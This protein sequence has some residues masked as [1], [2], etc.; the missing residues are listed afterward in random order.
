M[1]LDV[2]GGC[3]GYIDSLPSCLRQVG[4]YIE[5]APALTVIGD[6]QRELFRISTFPKDFDA[7]ER[8]GLTHIQ[9]PCLVIGLRTLPTGAFI[10]INSISGITTG[11]GCTR[12]FR[13][14]GEIHV[15]HLVCKT[16]DTCA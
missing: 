4:L 6:T 16:H 13:S 15:I 8:T 12:S 2:T 7:A 11:C 9:G 3:L 1:V 5:A 10:A 14:Q